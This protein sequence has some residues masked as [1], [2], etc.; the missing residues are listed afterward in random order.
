MPRPDVLI[1]ARGGGSVEDL[2]PFNDEALARAVAARDDPADLA[3]SGTRPT[4][5]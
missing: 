1:V 5:P 4:P 2:W 3:P